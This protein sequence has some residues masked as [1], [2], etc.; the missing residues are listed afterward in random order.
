MPVVIFGLT[1]VVGIAAIV[2]EWL[3]KEH[4]WSTRRRL[5]VL[6]ILGIGIFYEM[7]VSF[8]LPFSSMAWHLGHMFVTHTCLSLLPVIL[9]WI[10]APHINLFTFPF[11]K[12]KA[13]FL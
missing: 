4:G 6:V 9:V 12:Q 2:L 5:M 1:S 10:S 11:F 13:K 3:L 8:S 7:V